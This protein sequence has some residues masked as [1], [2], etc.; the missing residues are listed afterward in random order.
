[1]AHCHFVTAVSCLCSSPSQRRVLSDTSESWRLILERRAFRILRRDSPSCPSWAW[2]KTWS[3]AMR[4]VINL[5]CV[6]GNFR[7]ILILLLIE[8]LVLFI[9]IVNRSPKILKQF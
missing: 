8:I 7:K 9:L 5:I 4:N 2:N 1:M 6:G 3:V